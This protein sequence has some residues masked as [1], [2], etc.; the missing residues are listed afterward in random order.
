MR[1]V[2][3]REGDLRIVNCRDDIQWIIQRFNGGQW[4]NKSFHRTRQSLVRC[5]GPLQIILAPSGAP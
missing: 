5:Y 4:R 2:I 1:E 3:S